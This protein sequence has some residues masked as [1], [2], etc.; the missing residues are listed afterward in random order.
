M[1]ILNQLKKTRGGLK[2]GLR[3]TLIGVP[4]GGFDFD[5]SNYITSTNTDPVF[6]IVWK[7]VNGNLR[8]VVTADYDSVIRSPY[9]EHFGTLWF[10]RD[11]TNTL[12]TWAQEVGRL[13]LELSLNH[14]HFNDLNLGLPYDIIGNPNLLIAKNNTTIV[15]DFNCLSLIELSGKETLKPVLVKFEIASPSISS[16]DTHIDLSSATVTGDLANVPNFSYATITDGTNDEFIFMKLYDSTSSTINVQRGWGSSTA[17]SWNSS[18]TIYILNRSH[19]DNFDLASGSV[20]DGI[21]FYIVPH[22]RD[23]YFSSYY[24]LQNAY[25]PQDYYRATT[26]YSPLTGTEVSAYPD[27]VHHTLFLNEVYPHTLTSSKKNANFVL[28]AQNNLY[29]DNYFSDVTEADQGY[30]YSY[31]TSSQTCG[32]CKGPTAEPGTKCFVAADAWEAVGNGQDG[33]IEASGIDA[34]DRWNDKNRVENYEVPLYVTIA[35]GAVF[36]ILL[37]GLMIWSFDFIRHL[38]NDPNFDKKNNYWTDEMKQ[39]KDVGIATAVISTLSI[40]ATIAII[41]IALLRDPSDPNSRMFPVV[42]YNRSIYNAPPG[43]TFVNS[44]SH[45]DGPTPD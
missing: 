8:A 7:N 3:Y 42:N 35:L 4:N 25:S 21:D 2:D 37:I 18:I 45:E 17:R 23:A 43:Y 22:P 12:Q 16:I 41:L 40:L 20:L 15:D 11:G 39:I 28:K 29:T 6:F 5:S 19:L 44:P 10:T 27:G 31:C 32:T 38:Q 26:V 36:G 1:T 24:T 14:S 30:L 34:S 13:T 9:E 33:L